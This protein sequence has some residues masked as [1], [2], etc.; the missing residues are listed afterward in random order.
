MMGDHHFMS[1][2]TL[3]LLHIDLPVAS[4]LSLKWTLQSFTS[5]HLIYLWYQVG[6]LIM[7][8]CFYYGPH[9]HWT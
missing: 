4:Y 7:L 9:E 5:Y 2:F 8:V 3:L 1:L 6:N